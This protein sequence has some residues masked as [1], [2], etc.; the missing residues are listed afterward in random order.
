VETRAN[1]IL[2]GSFVVSGIA[3]AFLFALWLG[4]LSLER[5]FD[6][7]RVVFNEPVTGLTVGGDVRFNGIKVGEVK[8]I[9]IDPA[10][11]SRTIATID[12]EAG[13]PV[14]TDSAVRLTLQGITGL[15]YILI[16]G[17]S[18]DALLLKRVS[19]GDVP[20]MTADLSELQRLLANSEETITNVNNVLERAARLFSDENV[21]NISRA[22]E[23]VAVVTDELADNRERISQ[24][25]ERVSA[26]SARLDV[27]LANTE[28]LTYNLRTAS[29]KDLP[30]ILSEAETAMANL[31]RAAADIERLT[32]EA[33]PQFEAFSSE[34]LPELSRT[35]ADT[36]ALIAALNRIVRRAERSPR[37]LLSGE[38]SVPEYEGSEE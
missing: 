7:Y 10:D 25:V 29:E 14:K 11:P 32:E 6:R 23:N 36:R 8:D 9:Q 31:R 30:E 17:G 20:T 2:I 27:I 22:L 21:R 34:A 24:T 38:A 19:D 13:T 33:S 16:S 37:N 28:A 4:Q 35:V 1:H 3:A 18:P 15:S 26:L 5:S 12:V